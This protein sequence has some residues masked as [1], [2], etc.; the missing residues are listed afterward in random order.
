MLKALRGRGVGREK[1]G[2]FFLEMLH[3][4]APNALLNKVYICK[5]C[6]SYI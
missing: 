4:V 6:N 2:I 3:F 5:N 1:F